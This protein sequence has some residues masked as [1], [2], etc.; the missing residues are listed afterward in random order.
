MKY[1]NIFTLIAILFSCLTNS[2]KPI[3]RKEEGIII[4]LDSIKTDEDC[5]LYSSMYKGI[6]TILLETN[7]Y[8][9]IGHMD[10]IRVNKPYIII[11][12]S[13]SAKTILIFW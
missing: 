7:K 8:S 5:F 3:E 13:N 12:D 2:N 6:K 10:K 1:L 9:L 4:N 11:L